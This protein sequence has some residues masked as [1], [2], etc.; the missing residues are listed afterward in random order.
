M[1]LR[2]PSLSSKVG[3]L[4]LALTLKGLRRPAVRPFV[5][6]VTGAVAAGK[7]TLAAALVAEIGAWPETP[8]VE[9]VSTD[10]F[11]RPN[12]ELDAAGLTRRKGFPETYDTPA[13]TAA[14]NA[15]RRGAAT[16]PVY[17]HLTYDLDPS[18]ARRIDPPDVLI[19]EGLGFSAAT[20]LDVLVYLDAEEADVEAWYVRR[21][22]KF[23]EAGR[24]DAASFYARFAGLDVAGATKLAGVVWASI[25]LPNL[26]EHI[27]PLREIS[28]VVVRK[29][30]DHKIVGIEVRARSQS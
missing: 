26:H 30:P 18:L 29:G 20:P 5:V 9:V 19:V 4:D 25:N 3:N 28:D 27:A 6:G 21:F 22:L 14:L 10:G 2:A 7:S 24:T 15:I 17:S 23:W 13:M 11:L 16:F 1:S 8:R 12:A